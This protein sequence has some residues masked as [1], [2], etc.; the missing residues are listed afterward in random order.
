MNLSVICRRILFRLFFVLGWRESLNRWRLGRLLFA[1]QHCYAIFVFGWWLSL[2]INLQPPSSKLN[3]LR[4][5]CLCSVT[6]QL[7]RSFDSLNKW[8]WVLFVDGHCSVFFLFLGW[9]ES[10]NRWRC[11]RVVCVFEICRVAAQ[12][13]VLRCLGNLWA[14]SHC[15]NISILLLRRLQISL[16]CS[17]QICSGRSTL[18]INESECYL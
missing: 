13:S 5:S 11:G 3:N 1:R 7:Q 14:S 10:L 8:V 4:L 17:A 6:S 15:P 2:Q 16:S 12:P 9:R 18:S